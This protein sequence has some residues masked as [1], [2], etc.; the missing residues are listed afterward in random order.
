M[1]IGWAAWGVS[2][3]LGGRTKKSGRGCDLGLPL[4]IMWVVRYCF[5]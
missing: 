4:S 5:D 3:I 1:S 2:T